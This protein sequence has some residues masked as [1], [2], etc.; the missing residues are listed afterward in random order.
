MYFCTIVYVSISSFV[1]VMYGY[2]LWLKFKERI[3]WV[4]KWTMVK[5]ESSTVWFWEVRSSCRIHVIG[6]STTFHLHV[7]EIGWKRRY[8]CKILSKLWP[9]CMFTSDVETSAPSLF[10][11]VNLQ[12]FTRVE[13]KPPCTKNTNAKNFVYKV[14]L[15]NLF[16]YRKDA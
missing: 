4:I 1:S 14:W 9:L 12:S 16:I 2:E 8:R 13:K 6:H 11:I 3:S 5:L 7:K 10:E 15:W